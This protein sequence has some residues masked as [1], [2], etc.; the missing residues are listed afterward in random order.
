MAA[1]KGVAKR[2]RP[3]AGEGAES[4]APRVRRARG[5]ESEAAE[6][7]ATADGRTGSALSAETLALTPLDIML[8]AMR[9][10]FAAGRIEAAVAIAKEAAPYVHG[11]LSTSA[12]GVGSSLVRLEWV[13]PSG[14]QG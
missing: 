8:R 11:K 7:A 4:G 2:T 3:G 13:D 1:T 10:H 5:A 14:E 9:E 12:H 6:L